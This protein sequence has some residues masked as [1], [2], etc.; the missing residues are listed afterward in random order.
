[1]HKAATHFDKFEMQKKGCITKSKIKETINKDQI[2]LKAATNRFLQYIKNET[3]KCKA[4]VNP[5]WDNIKDPEEP[6]IEISEGHTK[7]SD[8]QCP[9]T[10]TKEDRTRNQLY[11]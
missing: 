6:P 2:R 7:I 3:N 8:Y 4:I 9:S 11:R 5:T 10:S 1:M